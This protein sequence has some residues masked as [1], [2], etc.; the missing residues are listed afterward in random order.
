[1]SPEGEL[2]N[3]HLIPRDSHTFVAYD[4]ENSILTECTYFEV[5]QTFEC[6][7]YSPQSSE[8]FWTESITAIPSY[9]YGYI[10]DRYLILFSRKDNSVMAIYL[11]NPTLEP[12]E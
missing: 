3:R 11:G 4:M 1:M 2:L 6:N 7:A 8:P 9:D 12:L 10:E 5:T